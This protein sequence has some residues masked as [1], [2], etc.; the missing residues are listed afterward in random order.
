MTGV[1][2]AA[3]V[4]AVRFMLEYEATSRKT[5]MRCGGSSAVHERVADGGRGHTQYYV[6][7]VSFQVFGV[8]VRSCLL[9]TGGPNLA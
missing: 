3:A 2:W 6:D 8:R 5:R 4:V 7:G 9:F 1:V